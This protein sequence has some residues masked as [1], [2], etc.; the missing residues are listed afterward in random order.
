MMA[1][2]RLDSREGILKGGNS[3]AALVPGDPD[4]SLIISKV[5]STDGDTRMPRGGTPLSDAQIADLTSW[6]KEGALLAGR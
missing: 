1:G 5:K 2:L 6:I 4:K 3:G